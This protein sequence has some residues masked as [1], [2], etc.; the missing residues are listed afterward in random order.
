MTGSHP[1]IRFINSVI[2]A[3]VALGLSLTFGISGV[4]NFAYGAFYV[5]AGYT[6]WILIRKLAVPF[7]LAAIFGG[8]RPRSCSCF[9]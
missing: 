8:C 4:S 1:D 6:V 2:K 3:L 9:R 7:P 5:L